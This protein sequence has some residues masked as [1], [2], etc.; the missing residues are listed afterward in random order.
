M[1]GRNEAFYWQLLLDILNKK[2]AASYSNWQYSLENSVLDPENSKSHLENLQSD[3]SNT[4][5]KLILFTW[6]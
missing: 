5:Y 4:I 2:W 1:E 3:I 6:I